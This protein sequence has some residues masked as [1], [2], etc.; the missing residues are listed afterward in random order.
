VVVVAGVLATFLLMPIAS[1]DHQPPPV[2]LLVDTF[3]DTFDG[4]CS[5]GECSLRDAVVS[6][7]PGERIGLPSGLFALSLGG[8]GGVDVGDI[9]LDRDVSI[10]GIGD[11]G[12]FI[13]ASALGDRAFHAR[14]GIS[15][16]L[17]RLTIIGGST[18][19]RGGGIAIETG[20]AVA[21][22]RTTISGSE[23]RNGGAISVTDATVLLRDSTL[24]AN[25]A[26]RRGGGISAHGASQVDVVASTFD[27]NM[28]ASGGGIWAS[29]QTALRIDRSTLARNGAETG[30]AIRTRATTSIERTTIARN[31]ATEGAAIVAH[32]RV[33]VL[34]SLVAANRSESGRP[35]V[36]KFRS[37]G[38]NV[39]T[40]GTIRCGFSAAT[41]RI[42]RDAGLGPFAGAGGPTPTI[43]LLP[44][45]PAIDVE[46]GCQARDQRGVRRDR[47]CDAGA[48]EWRRCLGRVVNVVGTR[49][50]DELSGGRRADGI[51]GQAGNDELQGSIGDDGICGGI[52]DDVVLG[53]PG[54]DRIEGGPG[55]NRLRGERGDDLLRGGG[56]RNLLA[57]GPGRDVCLVMGDDRTRSCEVVRQLPETVIG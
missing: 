34:G 51:L 5:D 3:A 11:T 27:A 41:D 1:A 42:V 35:C 37:R 47:R 52:G 9:D 12:T 40:R 48:Y 13:T 16:S 23:A 44:G 7:A 18:S 57:G 31:A 20:A 14:V 21:I 25:E 39:G 54:D 4:S 56:G 17:E 32:T 29:R 43:A 55:D 33:R 45:S 36:G 2:D 8:S 28:A 46:R 19:S 50:D 10:V 6:A 38:H 49:H 26:A 24:I 30:G 22:E 15:V 53:G